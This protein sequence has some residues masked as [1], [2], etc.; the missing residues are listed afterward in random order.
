MKLKP[1]NLRMASE[2]KIAEREREIAKKQERERLRLAGLC[3]IRETALS[4]GVAP[5]PAGPREECP[6]CNKFF[7]SYHFRVH[8][9]DGL[10]MFG[11][12]VCQP[13]APTTQ[14]ASGNGA[15]LINWPDNPAI[16]PGGTAAAGADDE[17][18]IYS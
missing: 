2:A 12:H 18:D 10:G 9:Q 8:N 13:C 5:C 11:G 3:Q 15:P 6:H 14:A 4:S 16:N 1:Q 17:D 7:C